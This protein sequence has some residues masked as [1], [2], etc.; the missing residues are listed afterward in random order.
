MN[1]FQGVQIM[2]DINI[3]ITGNSKSNIR[4]LMNSVCDEEIKKNKRDIKL[5]ESSQEQELII[6]SGHIKVDDKYRIDLYYANKPHQFE[7]FKLMPSDELKGL[8]IV[9][10]ANK[11]SDLSNLAKTILSHYYYL[12]NYSMCIGVTNTE[13]TQGFQSKNVNKLLESNGW[14]MPVFDIDIE[15]KQDFELLIEALLNFYKP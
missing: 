3:I 1:L 4:A 2:I 11:P 14:V 8:I 7:Y 13:G 6:Q 10:D 12:T 9:L 15:K 5:T